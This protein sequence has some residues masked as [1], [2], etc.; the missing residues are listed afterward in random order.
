MASK[1]NSSYL[2][3]IGFS[4][5]NAIGTFKFILKGQIDTERLRKEM[6]FLGYEC[7][8]MIVALTTIGCMILALNTAS[9]LDKHGGRKIAGALI[10]IANLR[11][12]LPIFIAF[13]I[14]A[15]SGTAIT[16]E[17]STM[18]VTEQVDALKVMRVDPVYYLIAPKILAVILLVPLLV[19]VAALISILAGMLVA[20]ISINMEFAQYLSSTWKAITMKEYFYPLIKTEV[21]TIYSLLINTSMGLACRGGAREVG[22]TTTRATAWVMIG[23]IVLD[24]VLTPILYT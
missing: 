24:G 10:G 20:N 9:E 22:L 4:L 6:V 21:F 18:K 3:L 23:I 5:Q 14:G 12:I 11:E 8:P 16:S 1:H 13:A 2:E 17:I 19:A 7:L 15:R